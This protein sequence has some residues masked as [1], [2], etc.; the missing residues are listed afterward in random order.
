M[1]RPVTRPDTSVFELDY[2]G[3]K[4]PQFSFTRLEGADPILGV[5]MASTGEV[6]CLGDDFEDAFLKAM[7]AVGFRFPLARVL[8][9]TGPIQNKARFLNDAKSLV[10]Q[11]VGLYATHGT[12]AFLEESGV[13]V[14][15][16]HWPL[17]E[18]SPNA[19]ELLAAR[20][21]DLVINIP[22]DAS[23]DEIRNDRLIRRG[24]VDHGIPLVTD[25]GLAQRLV[26]ALSRKP[27]SELEIKSWQ[28]Y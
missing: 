12:A 4:A 10:G 11:G 21:V 19:M 2:V 5:E 22:K 9:S 17:E 8:L 26:Q 23:A 3:V 16:V 7:L 6:A 1:D 28:E 13:A 15:T 20:E 27:L 25:I 14:K 24:A 18:K